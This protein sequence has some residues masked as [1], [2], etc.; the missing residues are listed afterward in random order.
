MSSAL[1]AERGQAEL[2]DTGRGLG[3]GL[4][5]V[6][7]FLSAFLLFQVQPMIAKMIV[8]WFGGSA[9]VW[10]TCLLFFQTVLLL[11]YLYAHGSMS[12]LKAP[13]RGPVHVGLLLV[14]LAALPS[15]I[16]LRSGSGGHWTPT[17]SE[18]PTGRI[19]LVLLATVGGPYF[20]LSTTGPLLQAWA[21]RLFTQGKSPYRLYA[22]SNTGSL[23]ALLGYP[24]L[25]EPTLTLRQQAVTWS[26]GYVLFVALCS[27]IA[28]RQ[29]R[30][31]VAHEANAAIGDAARP[32]V[33]MHLLW[34]GLAAVASV[35][36]LAV[37]NHL[38]QNVAAIPFLWVLPL[39]LYLLS[40]ILCFGPARWEWKPAFLPLPALAVGAMAYAHAQQFEN[41]SIQALIAVFAAGLFV[42]CILCHGELARLKP[43]PQYLTSFYLML[44]LG[45]ALGGAFVAL[46]AP[47]V[48]RDYY[49]LPLAIGACAL[50]ALFA[51]YREP[52]PRWW[53]DGAW[54]A[55]AAL[56]AGLIVSLGLDIRNTAHSFRPGEHNVLT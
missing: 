1:E 20:L 42:C 25:V 12:R 10:T 6:T 4:Y 23:L 27:L 56:T 26:V 47:H 28:W 38:S 46:V 24:V 34:M 39:T 44:S 29:P 15:L 31:G 41:L 54:W 5:A 2:Q 52:R 37:T 43:P 16:A 30:S 22:L 18:E 51:L 19:L 45:G 11:G 40:F 55:A 49:E 7:I 9:S 36:L 50:V 21:A 48:F 53:R 35:L 17:G 14:S 33:G 32:S 8:P 13:V 3:L